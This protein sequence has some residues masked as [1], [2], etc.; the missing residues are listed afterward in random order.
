MSEEQEKIIGH[1]E[2]NVRERVYARF[3]TFKGKRLF[4]IRIFYRDAQGGYQPTA[5]GV[6]IDASLFSELKR[7]VDQASQDP[8]LK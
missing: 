3:N 4:D 5:K 1:F 6:S 7:L 8:E 2:R